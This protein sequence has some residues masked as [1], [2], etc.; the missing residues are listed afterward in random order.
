M[1]IISGRTQSLRMEPCHL[2][3]A[4]VRQSIFD[5]RS[6]H[7]LGLHRQHCICFDDVGDIRSQLLNQALGAAG[8]RGLI[9]GNSRTCLSKDP[10]GGCTNAI[11][12]TSDQGYKFLQG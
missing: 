12:A 1:L 5:Y 2:R 11:G 7:L 9:D 10:T 3:R 4:Q 8:I 6:Q